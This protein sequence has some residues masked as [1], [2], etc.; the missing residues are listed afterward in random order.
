M[1]QFLLY[2]LLLTE[3]VAC[4]HIPIQ[5]DKPQLFTLENPPVWG[6]TKSGDNVLAGGF[7]GLIYLGKNT[8]NQELQF[9]AHTDRGP[10]GEPMTIAKIGKDLRPFLL[11][12]FQLRWVKLETDHKNMTLKII[13]ELLL[14]DPNGKALRG[15]AQWTSKETPWADETPIN[16]AENLILPDSMGID[17]ESICIDQDGNYWMGEEYRPSI[18]KFNPQG[19]LQK[20]FIPNNSM[21]NKVVDKINKKYGRN[22]ILA[23]LPEDYKYRKS[24]RG[25]EGIACHNNKIYAILQSPL[26][27]PNATQR[28]VIR[29]LEFDIASETVSNEFYYPL[30]HDK[31][32]KIG[33]LSIRP[34]STEFFAIEQNSKIGGT[35]NHLITSFAL[36]SSPKTTNPE[37]STFEF[38]KDQN[39]LL[40]LTSRLDLSTVG[41]NFA[42]KIEGLTF[43]SENQIAVINDNDFGVTSETGQNKKLTIDNTKKTVLGIFDLDYNKN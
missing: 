15:I 21:P 8:K 29:V 32:D 16:L 17:P 40:T 42:E 3:L 38:L 33:D 10:N 27:M 37:L 30:N 2:T 39:A 41:Y 36:N 28:K 1:K 34:N 4:S 5:E 23:K 25:F 14:T 13:D 19:Q 11:P 31:I 7:S 6:T 26:E 12:D 9:L 43:I 22:V 24:N 35:G 20:R 18:L